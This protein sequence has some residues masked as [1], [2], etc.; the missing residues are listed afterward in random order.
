MSLSA[1]GSPIRFAPKQGMAAVKNNSPIGRIPKW[2]NKKPARSTSSISTSSPSTPLEQQ[3]RAVIVKNEELG[4]VV[5]K[6][7]RGV[8]REFP[9]EQGASAGTT[10]SVFEPGQHRICTVRQTDSEAEDEL[11]A[12]EQSLIDE[13]R[14]KRAKKGRSVV[15]D[16]SVKKE[17]FEEEFVKGEDVFVK[18]ENFDDDKMNDTSSELAE[19][20]AL[21]TERE[22]FLQE[23]EVVVPV[24]PQANGQVDGANCNVLMR[25]EPNRIAGPCRIRGKQPIKLPRKRHCATCS[26]EAKADGAIVPTC[27]DHKKMKRHL[28]KFLACA[29][30]TATRQGDPV[31][32]TQDQIFMVWMKGQY[33][34]SDFSA[35]LAHWVEL[36]KSGFH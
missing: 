22:G 23:N 16:L 36:R 12:A 30:K 15:S 5:V 9:F 32:N 20:D 2:W 28:Q 21:A 3:P 31:P 29:K 25:W 8:K 18:E 26:R 34:G 19:W 11:Y 14:Q 1:T 17:H 24:T 6:E 10:E 7:E 4:G 27:A 13:H 33:P 35:I